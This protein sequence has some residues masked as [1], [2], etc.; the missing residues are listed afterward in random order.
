M[1]DPAIP[2]PATPQEVATT[3]VE[4]VMDHNDLERAWPL[5][6]PTLRLVL[7][8]DWIWAHRHHPWVGHGRDWDVLARSLAAARPDH[9][10]WAKFK[11]EQLELWHKIWSGFSALTWRAPEKPEV[12]DLDLE[13]VTFVEQA[14]V[15]SGT[16]RPSFARRFALRHTDDGWQVA[17][18]NG[19]QMFI[20]GWPPSMEVR[21]D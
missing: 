20:P 1:A 9:K 12:V 13:T 5:T 3:W 14:E 15:S 21:S 11:V 19:D 4:A 6:D 2:L 16:V 10:L 7:V 18:I 8:Q 17:S